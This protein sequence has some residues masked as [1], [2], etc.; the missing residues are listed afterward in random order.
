M[1][2][3]IITEELD[4]RDGPSRNVEIGEVTWVE[5]KGHV[6]DVIRGSETR[7]LPDLQRRIPVCEEN[8]RCILYLWQP[9]GIYEFLNEPFSTWVKAREANQ[10]YLEEDLSKDAVC[11]FPED[12]GEDNGDTVVRSLDID[13]LLITVMDSH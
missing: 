2:V 1:I 4:V 5:Y 12:C 7:H 11:F 13:S 3:K 10:G 8:L 9:T 6:A